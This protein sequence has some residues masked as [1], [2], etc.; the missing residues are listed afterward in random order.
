MTLAEHPYIRSLPTIDDLSTHLPVFWPGGF[1]HQF[2]YWSDLTGDFGHARFVTIFIQKILHIWAGTD[3]QPIT[4][5]HVRWAISIVWTRA[6]GVDG[7]SCLLPI[8]DLLNH[9]HADTSN[10]EWVCLHS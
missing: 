3:M 6:A 10:V 1:A 5:Q 7:D 2:P 8:F 4:D 9:H